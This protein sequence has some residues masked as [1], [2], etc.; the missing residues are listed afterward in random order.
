MKIYSSFCRY[1]H[2]HHSDFVAQ[3]TADFT[4]V[5][6][7]DYTYT[8]TIPSSQYKARV[9]WYQDDILRQDDG[10]DIVNV[11]HSDTYVCS[12]EKIG[13]V[14]TRHYINLTFLMSFNILAYYCQI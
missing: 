1:F 5:E 8:C 7:G 13:T 11:E 3:P 10:N 9:T 6:G 4:I 12:T 2:K 14:S